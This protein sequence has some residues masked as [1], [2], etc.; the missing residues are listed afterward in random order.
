MLHASILLVKTDMNLSRER[1]IH[2]YAQLLDAPLESFHTNGITFASTPV[3]DLPE[4]ANWIQPIWLFG[5]E[6]AVI[7]STSPTYAEAAKASFADVTAATLLS[8]ESLAHAISITPKVEAEIE[9]VRCE[10]F[11]YPHVRAP[12]IN[13]GYKIEKLQPGQPGAAKHLLNFD[14]GVYVIRGESKE[15]T[16]AAFVKNK[17]LIHESAVGTEEPYRRQGRAK[18]VVAQAIQEILAQNA[19]PTYWPDSFENRGSYGVA[20]A[21]GMVKGAEMLF[22]CYEEAGWQGFTSAEPN[23]DHAKR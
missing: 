20:Q 8:E 18:A 12:Q 3:R 17:G 10:L 11:Y 9:W 21:V 22:C 1:F 16:A 2:G 19:L 23:N 7:C 5:F 15:I 6:G 13:H 14:G 4:W